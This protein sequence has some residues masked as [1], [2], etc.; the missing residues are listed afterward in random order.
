MRPALR[1]AWRGLGFIESA[2]RHAPHWIIVA[3]VLVALPSAAYALAIYTYQG[4]TYYSPGA[5]PTSDM[6]INR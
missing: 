5:E 2:A 6:R 4:A 3:A 1:L